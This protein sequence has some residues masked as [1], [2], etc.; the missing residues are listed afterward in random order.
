[1]AVLVRVEAEYTAADE[2]RGPGLDAADRGV[3]VF[4]RGGELAL[5]ERAAHRLVLALRHLSPEHQALGAAA[6]GTDDADDA[7]EAGGERRQ[8]GGPDLAAPGFGEPEG[9]RQR[10]GSGFSHGRCIRT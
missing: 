10:R 3:A 7:D 2:R 1:V 8:R 5:L 9:A 6:D 4:D